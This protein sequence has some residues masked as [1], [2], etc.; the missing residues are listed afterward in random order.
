MTSRNSRDTSAS[1]S[2]RTLL[3]AG[4]ATLGAAAFP[5]PGIAQTKPFAG[6]T[7]RVARARYKEWD[8]CDLT[9]VELAERTAVA[10]VFLGAGWAIFHILIVVLQAFIFMM[11]TVVYLSMAHESH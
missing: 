5:M 11:L 7:L 6:V 10:G 9:Y 4:A 3:Q 8:R 2:R 1:V